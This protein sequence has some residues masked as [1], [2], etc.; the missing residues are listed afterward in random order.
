MKSKISIRN[1]EEFLSELHSEVNQSVDKQFDTFRKKLLYALR[2]ATPID[3]GVARYGWVLTPKSFV[4]NVEYID[5]L[6][7]GSSRQ[8][9]NRFIEK[10]LLRH[11]GV[12]PSGIIVRHK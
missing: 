5:E 3:T 7:E 6:N 11:Q 2:K 8:A 12:K 1:K 4:N 10:T 9:P